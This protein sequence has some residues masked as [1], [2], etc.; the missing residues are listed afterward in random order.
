MKLTYPTLAAIAIA[1]VCCSGRAVAD[2]VEAKPGATI[3]HSRD[4][5][6]A[7]TDDA[8]PWGI[9]SGAEWSGDYP[10]F[11]PMLKKAGVRWLRL[12]PEWQTIQPHKDEW[13]WKTADAMVANARANDIHL[14]GVLCYLAPWA[15][16]DGGTRKFPIKD[17]QVSGAITSA[18]TVGRYKERRR[19]TGR[20][21]TSSTA[22]S[23]T[24]KTR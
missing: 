17:I 22:A 24:R 20:S 4:Q 8:G 15:S 14:S 10:K 21:G 2:G 16:A 9:A 18:G 23:A 13:N 12:F 11:N 6:Q 7:A 5:V 19:S 1:A 3:D